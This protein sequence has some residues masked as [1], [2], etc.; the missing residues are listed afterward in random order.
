M[1][2]DSAVDIDPD[3]KRGDGVAGGGYLWPRTLFYYLENDMIAQL[4]QPPDIILLELFYLQQ[5][6]VFTYRPV[7]L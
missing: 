1:D 4:R 5:L 6:F 3:G 7:R 2:V